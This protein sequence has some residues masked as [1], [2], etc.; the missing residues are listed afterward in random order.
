MGRVD[1]SRVAW[2]CKTPLMECPEVVALPRSRTTLPLIIRKKMLQTP[3]W[4]GKPICQQ[5]D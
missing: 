5:K 4:K 2:I 1:S 3:C